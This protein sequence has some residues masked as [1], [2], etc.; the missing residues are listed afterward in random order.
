MDRGL[1]YRENFA[2]NEPA[3][4]A[5]PVAASAA[6]CMFAVAKEHS[7]LELL[8]LSRILDGTV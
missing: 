6:L 1:G 3:Q 4:P 8:G 7:K 2:A 5:T